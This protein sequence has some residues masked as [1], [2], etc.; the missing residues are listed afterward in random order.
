MKTHDDT[1]EELFATSLGD[2]FE[3]QGDTSW[4]NLQQ[5][6]ASKLKIARRKILF[7]ASGITVSMCLVA[8]IFFISTSSENNIQKPIETIKTNKPESS[9]IKSTESES[10]TAPV[11]QQIKSDETTSNHNLPE[12]G[13]TIILATPNTSIYPT[14][15]NNS[16]SASSALVQTIENEKTDTIKNTTKPKITKK[17]VVV[18]K[19]QVLVKDTVVKIVKKKVRQRN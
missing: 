19:N 15:T 13:E 18:Q 10:T 8:A 5:L 3:V 4:L 14:S 16:D 1:I 17:I 11:K 7:I 12:K 6:R 9:T 2:Q